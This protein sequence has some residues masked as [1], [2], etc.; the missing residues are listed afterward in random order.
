MMVQRGILKHGNLYVLH[1]GLLLFT[2]YFVGICLL[3]SSDSFCSLGEEE[4]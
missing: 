4:M 2:S 1:I 3:Q